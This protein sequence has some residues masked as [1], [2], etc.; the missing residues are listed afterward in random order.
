MMDESRHIAWETLNDFADG[1]LEPSAID[2]VQ[3]HLDDCTVCRAELAA[4]RNTVNSIAAGATAN[5][6]A[7]L[8]RD[9]RYSISSS[10]GSVQASAT[11][12]SSASSQS[13]RFRPYRITMPTLAAAALLLIVASVSGTLIIDRASSTVSD[14]SSTTTVGNT[15]V[16]QLT[17]TDAQFVPGVEALERQLQSQRAA[18]RPAT[19]ATIEKS[20]STIDA[21]LLEARAALL[22][23]PANAALKEVL[24]STYRHKMDFLTR[25][26]QIAVGN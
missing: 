11:A 19:I 7:D 14:I 21:A 15:P 17:A 25:A 2:D 26:A 10:R 16:L 8:W 9:V 1:M 20:L 18:L 6:P 4:L 5:I 12:R 13:I 3:A 24:E 22:A 23:D